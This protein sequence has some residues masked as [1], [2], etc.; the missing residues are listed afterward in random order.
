MNKQHCEDCK[1]WETEGYLGKE[2][3]R[4]LKAE[5]WRHSSERPVMMR[6]EYDGGYTGEL[7]T[8][9]L[10]YCNQFVAK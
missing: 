7:E 9:R 10:F 1:W 8:Y 4:C 3:G 5:S 6:A 2:Y